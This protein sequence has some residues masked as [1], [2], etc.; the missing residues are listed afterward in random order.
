MSGDIYLIAMCFYGSRFEWEEDGRRT[1]AK[2]HIANLHTI[3]Q[4]TLMLAA[5][6]STAS[7][8]FAYLIPLPQL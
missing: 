6:N 1:R 3:M 7:Q 5:A 2:K 8:L 4:H